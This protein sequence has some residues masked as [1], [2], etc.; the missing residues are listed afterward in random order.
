MLMKHRFLE[1]T[2]RRGK[3]FAA[4]LYLPR[5]PGDKSIRSHRQSTGLLIDYAED[6]RPIGIEITA[7]SKVTLTSLNQALAAANQDP[8]TA[9]DLAPLLSAQPPAS[10][11]TK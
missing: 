10:A 5:N 2:F 11:V 1:I 7:P 6:G 8:V 3:P 9:D 4:Y